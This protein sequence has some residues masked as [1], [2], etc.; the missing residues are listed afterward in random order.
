[1]ATI[2]ESEKLPRKSFALVFNS[3][4][5]RACIG[6]KNDQEKNCQTGVVSAS[7][8]GIFVARSEIDKGVNYVLTAGHSCSSGTFKDRFDSPGV[9]LAILGHDI[10]VS[11]YY[12]KKYPATI[13]KIEKQ[14]DM[15]LLHVH[16]ITRQP[17]PAKI[18][19]SSP[20]RGSLSY[21][22][23]APLGIFYPKMVMTMRGYFSGY[24]ETGYALYTIPTKPGSSGSAVF[25][26]TGEIIGLIF[27]GYHG[28]ENVAITSPHAALKIFVKNNIALGEM[29]LFAKKKVQQQLIIERLK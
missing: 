3:V 2:S 20:E 13:I 15:C 8:S 16:G 22:L 11:T 23:A 14:Y 24:N 5:I 4:K 25:N 7:S 12:G 18:A 1:M 19:E 21:N 27:A 17:R 26:R 6:K 9:T 29:A 28:I 10:T